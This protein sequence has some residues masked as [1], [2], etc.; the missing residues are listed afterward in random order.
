[1]P[2]PRHR[3][4]LLAGSFAFMS[5]HAQ[6]WERPDPYRLMVPQGVRLPGAP[7]HHARP[8]FAPPP[9]AQA[10]PAGVAPPAPRPAG[11]NRPAGPPPGPAHQAP[12][13][14]TGIFAPRGAQGAR[15]SPPVAQDPPPGGKPSTAPATKGPAAGPDSDAPTG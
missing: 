15:V 11:A 2:R 14:A 7:P 9:P 5:Q 8:N 1:M 4:V 13:R 12:D 3:L 10:V 6:A